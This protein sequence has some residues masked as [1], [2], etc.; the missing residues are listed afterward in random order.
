[1]TRLVGVAHTSPAAH[2][3]ASQEIWPR[4]LMCGIE[5][6]NLSVVDFGA[7]GWL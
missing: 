1:M 3:V 6:S 4:P 7:T 5:A 2:E